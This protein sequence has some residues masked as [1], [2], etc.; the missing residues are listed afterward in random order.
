[1][2]PLLGKWIQCICQSKSLQLRGEKKN[3]STSCNHA[4]NTYS[5][6]KR[7]FLV[8][9]HT[10]ALFFSGEKSY[11]SPGMEQLRGSWVKFVPLKV[12][13]ILNNLSFPPPGNQRLSTACGHACPERIDPHCL[14]CR[15]EDRR[16]HTS[17]SSCVL[18]HDNDP[19]S[20][21]AKN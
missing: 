1:M 17:P 12:P 20:D 10:D 16:V 14:K 19:C 21:L 8:C 13:M 3:K 7:I 11:Q 15:T 4:S 9:S 5:Q 18:C 6:Q 2:S